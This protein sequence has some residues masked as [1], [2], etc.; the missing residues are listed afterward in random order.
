MSLVHTNK[1]GEMQVGK[2]ELRL[3]E[4]V[5]LGMTDYKLFQLAASC[6]AGQTRRVALAILRRATFHDL[7]LLCANT[8]PTNNGYI[9]IIN[10]QKVMIGSLCFMRRHSVNTQFALG[11]LR[12]L[13]S[14]GYI[15][16]FVS[17]NGHLA[18]VLGFSE[19]NLNYR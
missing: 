12:N 18:G 5:S 15:V 16:R 13:I 4:A 2:T 11:I 1:K 6:V 8:I 9:A 14:E 7:P 17:V 10:D 19:I 3:K